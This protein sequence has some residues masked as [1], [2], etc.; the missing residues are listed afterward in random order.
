MSV[1]IHEYRTI[2]RIDSFQSSILS[3]IQERSGNAIEPDYKQ[4]IPPNLLRRMNKAQRLGVGCALSLSQDDLP[5]GIVVG[6]GIGCYG[7]SIKFTEHYLEKTAGALSPTAFTQS[8]DNT[9]AGQIAIIQK[10]GGYNSTYI[11]KG[12]SFEN[13]LLDAFLLI[14]EGKK[15]ILI[16][17]VDER[18]EFFGGRSEDN[19]GEGSSFFT[20]S[21]EISPVRLNCSWILN[22]TP[23]KIVDDVKEFLI[24][25]GLEKPDLVL[26]GQSFLN[27]VQIDPVNLS[28]RIFDYS[29]VSGVYFTNSAFAVQM[30]CEI[31]KFPK[32]AL[33]NQLQAKRILVLNDFYNELYGI[34]YISE[35]E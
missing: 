29:A 14:L 26:Y 24:K 18:L 6:T 11:H 10:N 20:V 4:Y 13:A 31:I 35:N 5:D 23:E 12:V 15:K 8:T 2:S 17:G 1:Y 22:S 27:D 30:A 28:E 32:Q 9:I 33:K 19:I 3:A 16:G 34:T 25:N 21:S 7:N